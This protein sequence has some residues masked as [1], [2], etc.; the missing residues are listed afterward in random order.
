MDHIDIDHALLAVEKA[1]ERDPADWEAWAAKADLLCS[2]KMYDNA[3]R[4]CDRS[5]EQNPKNA[6]AWNTKG[7]ALEQ[8]GNHS[9]AADC[10]DKAKQLEPG[11]K[12]PGPKYHINESITIENLFNKAKRSEVL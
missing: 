9:D 6:F 7:D 12:L 3:I 2:A 1:L 5:L 8:I 4:C 11:I 10:Y